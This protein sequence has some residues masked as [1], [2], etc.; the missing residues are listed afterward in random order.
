M[1]HSP[2]QLPQESNGLVSEDKEHNEDRNGLS[3]SEDIEHNHQDNGKL[4]DPQDTNGLVSED[5]NLEEQNHHDSENKEPIESEED[6]EQNHH[7][8]EKTVPIESEEDNEQIKEESK[9]GLVEEN[10]KDEKNEKLK[11]PNNRD[12]EVKKSMESEE[13]K[14]Q[15]Y[16]DSEKK[17]PIESEVNNEQ[18]KEESKMGIVENMKDDKKDVPDTRQKAIEEIVSVQ[19]RHLED[20]NVLHDIYKRSFYNAV[21]NEEIPLLLDDLIL[22]FDKIEDLSRTNQMF[23]DILKSNGTDINMDI[24]QR[25]ANGRSHWNHIGCMLVIIN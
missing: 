2:D 11:V 19:T 15:N 21:E 4:S 3:I 13:D 23:L 1:T 5:K 14:E 8:S 9:I 17:V 12:S 20:I 16:H 10:R 22:L 18:I 25:M 24:G 7:D 6:N